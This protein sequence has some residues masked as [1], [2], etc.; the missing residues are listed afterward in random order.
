MN[1]DNHQEYIDLVYGIVNGSCVG[2]EELHK[3]IIE[4]CVSSICLSNLM[5]LKNDDITNEC[6]QKNIIMTVRKIEMNVGRPITQ[7]LDSLCA[8]EKDDIKSFRTFETS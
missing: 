7:Y 3:P 1:K 8:Y 2:Q 5:R 6:L 4:G